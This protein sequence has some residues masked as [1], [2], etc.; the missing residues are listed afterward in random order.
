MSEQPGRL[1]ALEFPLRQAR[2][3]AVGLRNRIADPAH[4]ADRDWPGH[5]DRYQEI[6]R[7]VAAALFVVLLV[8]IGASLLMVL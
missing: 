5:S 7:H 1:R 4:L 8:A 2:R 3:L 6:R